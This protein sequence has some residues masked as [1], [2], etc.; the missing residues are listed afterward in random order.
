MSQPPD[1][2]RHPKP[3]GQKGPISLGAE[4]INWHPIEF[5][6]D[7]AERE[8]MIAQVFVRDIERFHS[9]VCPVSVLRQNEEADLDFIISTAHGRRE[10]ELAEVAPLNEFQGKRMGA[11]RQTENNPYANVPKQL[12]VGKLSEIVCNLIDQKSEHQGGQNRL[13]LLYV[14]HAPL[15]IPTPTQELVRRTLER[16]APRFERIYFISPHDQTSGTIFKLF[17]APPHEWFANLSDQ[18][19]AEMGPIRLDLDSSDTDKP[20]S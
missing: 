1:R 20:G 15:F 16:N 5:P 18:Q 2:P 4:G 7:K 6:P 9:S 3:S 17:P 8:M 13:L 14:T 10:L 12:T 19:L 11:P